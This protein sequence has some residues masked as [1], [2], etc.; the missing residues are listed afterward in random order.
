VRRECLDHILIVNDAHLKLVIRSHARNYNDHR[1]HQGLSQDI[2]A[3]ERTAQ[4]AVE[5]T[6][7]VRHRH[8][9]RHRGRIHR[10][11]RLGGQIHEYD[12]VA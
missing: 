6:S 12:R 9:H 1:P 8:L 10:H 5:P 7:K 2:P 4:L 3:R 11:D